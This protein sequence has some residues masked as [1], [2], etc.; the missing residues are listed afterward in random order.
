MTS[1]LSTKISAV[2][3]TYNEAGRLGRTLTSLKGIVDEIIIVDSNSIDNTIDVAKQFGARTYN[4]SFDDGFGPQKRYAISKANYDWVLCLDA[5][6]VLDGTLKRS[7]ILLKKGLSKDPDPQ[8]EIVAYSLRRRLVFLGR[9]LRFAGESRES[10]YRFF[11]RKYANYDTARVHEKVLVSGKK[12]ALKGFL[13]H[14]SYEN[15]YSY[16]DKFNEFTEKA[17]RQ[18]F[19]QK[20]KKPSLFS[21][22]FRFPFVFIKIYIIKLG[23]LDGYYGF[24]WAL[25]SSIAPLVKYTK[26]VNMIE[27]NNSTHSL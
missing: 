13:I 17:A 16:F 20:K 1:S 14:Y 25:F 12:G 5:D 15:L 23:F 7:I 9:I 4:K 11:H 24:L 6:E 26:Y 21:I 10:L 8:K 19:E 18:L 22:L 3:I 2:I 27:R